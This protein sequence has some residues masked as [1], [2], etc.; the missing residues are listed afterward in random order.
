MSSLSLTIPSYMDK[1]KLRQ[2]LIGR[3][4]LKRL[5][6]S[7]ITVYLILMLL[8][9]FFTDRFIFLDRKSYSSDQGIIR[10]KTSD[11]FYLSAR[12]FMNPRAKYTILYSH[13]NGE[14]IGDLHEVYEL[15]FTNG[16][17]VFAWDYRGYG[18]SEGRCNE[19]RIYKDIEAVYQY[20]I[21]DLKI[22]PERIILLGRS[23]GSAPSIHLAAHYRVAALITESALATAYSAFPGI[24]I[25]PF[26]K[27]KNIE[28]ITKVDCPKLFVHGQKDWIV[29]IKNSYA[30][31][32]QA[33]E[34]KLKFWHEDSSHN[35]LRYIFDVRY[36]Q[37]LTELTKL[38]PSSDF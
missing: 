14:D 12:H 1:T 38:I 4:T 2:L 20:M 6:R 27:Y 16:Y 33:G 29:R 26:D 34:P 9:F 24:R 36:W 31:Y 3:F 28:K 35:D 37:K 23:I 25:F 5:V 7:V 18:T 21:V 10:I 15:Y 19:K 32:A 11:D 17:S 22:P 30:L 8:A 13:G